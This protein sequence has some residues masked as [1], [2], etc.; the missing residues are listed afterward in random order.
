MQI[1]SCVFYLAIRVN[2]W[3]SIIKHILGYVED[4]EENSTEGPEYDYGN[5]LPK[6]LIQYIF[7]TLGI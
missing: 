3:P 4:T 2:L 7:N 5:T 6:L 1:K